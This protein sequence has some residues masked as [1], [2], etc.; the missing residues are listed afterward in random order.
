MAK[1]KVSSFICYGV[2][3][4]ISIINS[5]RYNIRY[6]DIMKGG[7]AQK[8]KKLLNIIDDSIVNVLKKK[9]F[10]NKY[11]EKHTQGIAVNFYGQTINSFF[12]DFSTKSNICLLALDRIED[13]QNFGQII[14]TA[15]CA[16]IDGILF[17]KHYSAPVNN[18]VLQVS[19]GA[20]V[21]VNLY[22]ITN[23]SQTI[24]QLKNENFWVIGLENGIKAK[25]WH[26]IEYT[27]RVIIVI[28]SEGRGIRKKIL[29][30]CDFISTIPMQG[31]VNSLNVSAAVSAIAFERLR[32]I[33]EKN[34]GIHT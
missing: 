23:L 13:P 32:Q 28:G 5:N 33:M 31:K 10:L 8:N 7:N 26:E 20:F 25:L 29:D 3:S 16:G 4:A 19:Q 15:D 34:N 30:S 27:N 17:S 6:I 18:T 1:E 22:E 9:E 21:N 24:K 12:P 2:N 11:P 14:R